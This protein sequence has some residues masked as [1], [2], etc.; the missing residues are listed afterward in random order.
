MPDSPDSQLRDRLPTIDVLS[1]ADLD[2]VHNEPVVFNAVHDTGL[3]LTD[4]IPILTGE[5]LTTHRAR[6][7]TELRNP[8]Y[9]SLAVL[10]SGNGLDLLHGRGFDQNPIL[11][12]YVSFP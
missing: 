2:D 4:S 1:L 5:L 9:D 11:P 10:L 3:A 6:V 8:P 12:H 7:V